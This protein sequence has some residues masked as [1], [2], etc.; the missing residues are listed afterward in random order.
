M[1]CHPR[2]AYMTADLA[3][4]A[5]RTS[6]FPAG[7]A[8]KA[9]LAQ[10]LRIFN[11]RPRLLFAAVLRSVNEAQQMQEALVAAFPAA[12]VPLDEPIISGGV[13]FLDLLQEGL[14]VAIA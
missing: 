12:T 8:S 2:R 14:S 1:M 4:R 6:P 9:Q 7:E 13:W 3:S 10:S 5:T 11:F